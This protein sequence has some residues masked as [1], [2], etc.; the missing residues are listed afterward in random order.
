MKLMSSLEENHADVDKLRMIYC[1][2]PSGE[3][4][5]FAGS[6]EGPAHYRICV[7]LF[8]DFW[9]ERVLMNEINNKIQEFETRLLSPSVGWV[10]SETFHTR[11]Y[12][13]YN[14][15]FLKEDD[16]DTMMKWLVEIDNRFPPDYHILN[17]KDC[18]QI[19]ISRHTEEEVKT[20]YQWCKDELSLLDEQFDRIEKCWFHHRY[21]VANSVRYMGV[22]R[23]YDKA[24]AMQFKLTWTPT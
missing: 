23:F 18:I 16:A 8:T 11:K 20:I 7:Q 19:R 6:I 13:H 21:S 22:I 1:W 17:D 9:R 2:G 14:F 4:R 15:D 12:V 3:K 24:Q 5:Y 10:E